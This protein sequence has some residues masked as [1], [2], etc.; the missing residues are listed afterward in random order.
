MIFKTH[1]HDHIFSFDWQISLWYTSLYT[2]FFN[3]IFELYNISRNCGNTGN[4]SRVPQSNLPPGTTAP[5]IVL[6][7]ES[8][9]THDIQLVSLLNAI[10]ISRFF[11]IKYGFNN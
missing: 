3:F 1:S 4:S 6:A 8:V 9:S 2:S 10:I 7:A 11:L 5:Q